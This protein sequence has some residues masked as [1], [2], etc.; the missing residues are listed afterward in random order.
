L[1]GREIISGLHRV[2]GGKIVWEHGATGPPERDI[3]E[4]LQYQYPLISGYDKEANP[5]SWIMVP[6]RNN[7]YPAA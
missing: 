3:D 7:P 1:D 2:S 5:A 4:N 6:P